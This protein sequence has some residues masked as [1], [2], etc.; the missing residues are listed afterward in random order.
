MATMSEIAKSAGV[1]RYTV[2]KVLNGAHV[3]EETY[4]RVL[5]A[6]EK[7]HYTRNLHATNLVR[8]HSS[9]IGMV[10]SQDY[11]SFF[12]EIINAA[13]KEAALQGYQLICQCSHGDPREEEK[14]IRSFESLRICGMIAAPVTG[15]S[16]SALWE[17]LDQKMPLVHFDCFLSEDSHYV[18]T[19][20]RKS[21]GLITEHLIERQTVP[22]YLG[23]V[24]TT[25]NLAVKERCT[26]Y[27]ETVTKHGLTPLMIPTSN[28]EESVDNQ[29]FGIENIEAYL[30]DNPLPASIFCATD[31]IAM[32]VIF[33]LQQKGIKVG[34]DVLVAGHDDL[35]FGEYMNPTLTT[36]AQ[37]RKDLGTECI[38]TLFT[39]LNTSQVPESR[40]QKVLP[41]ELIIRKSTTPE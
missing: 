21:A 37:P 28:S 39:L 14:I 38:R 33:A 17:Y 7:H 19:D 13:E 34:S 26:G 20:N 6:C 23:S 36:V 12:G 3:A 25:A 15:T 41:P 5:E 31:R 16:N 4:R 40:I 32:G 27:L 2:S 8:N 30:K 29:K 10:L 24:H 11:D 9:I 22:A 18:I 35:E 1:S